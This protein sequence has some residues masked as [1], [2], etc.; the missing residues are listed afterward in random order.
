MT[1]RSTGF[2]LIELLVVISIIGMLA[3]IVLVSLSDAR[4]KAQLGRMAED[5]HSIEVQLAAS[6]DD[7][8]INMTQNGCTACSFN[9]SQPV[10]QQTSALST[11]STTWSRL[12]F[13]SS[14]I[15]PWGNPY[16]IDENENEWS[17]ELCRYDVVYSAGPNG[18]WHSWVNSGAGSV[19][20]APDV[21]YTVNGDNYAAALTFYKCTAPN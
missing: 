12:G 9:T 18:I 5:I 21:V 8:I 15:D 20:A 14:P 4:L 7:Y 6:R 1:T 16:L 10:S 3:A 19:F 11:L 2:T 13:A 17:G